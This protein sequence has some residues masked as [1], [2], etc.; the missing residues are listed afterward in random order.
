[1]KA[2]TIVGIAGTVCGILFGSFQTYMLWQAHN[3]N[4]EIAGTL[5]R[6]GAAS[7]DAAQGRDCENAR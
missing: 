1:M 6:A 2:Q 3:D 4:I 5:A 7:A